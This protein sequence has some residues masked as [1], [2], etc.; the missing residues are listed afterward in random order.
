MKLGTMLRTA[1]LLLGLAPAVAGAAPVAGV[2]PGPVDGA[3][4]RKL[5]SAGVKVVDVRTPAE[6]ATGHVPGAINIPHDQMAAR[7]AEVGPP[8]TPVILYCRSGRRTQV[9]A[10]ALREKGFDTIYDLQSYDRWVESEPEK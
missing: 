4:A 2:P 3:T 5:V 10:A 6:F 8:S 7:H 1:A 9:A